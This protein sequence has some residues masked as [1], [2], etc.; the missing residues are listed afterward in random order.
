LG[1][2][3][4]FPNFTYNP[5]VNPHRIRD[6]L[7]T[8]RKIEAI[9]VYR[10]QTGAGLREAKEAVDAIERELHRLLSPM[11]PSSV[12]PPIPSQPEP[13]SGSTNNLRAMLSSFAE[14]LSA[15]ALAESQPGVYERDEEILQV[16]QALASPLKGKVVLV[17]PPRTSKRSPK[18]KQVL[19]G[20]ALQ[21][22]LDEALQQRARRKN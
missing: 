6:L 5:L 19:A 21:E 4:G 11:T 15:R 18:V 20:D 16:L 2:W 14:N 3:N 9:K 7:K 17:G 10:R 13:V 1:R 12:S 22:F 8:G